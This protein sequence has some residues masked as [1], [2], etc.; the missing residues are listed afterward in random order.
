[1]GYNFKTSHLSSQQ[2]A[3]VN[4]RE[5]NDEIIKKNNEKTGH[6][7]NKDTVQAQEKKVELKEKSEE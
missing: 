3:I 5:K 4:Q 2:R 1:M 7:M 6:I